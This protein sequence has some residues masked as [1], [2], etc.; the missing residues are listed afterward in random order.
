MNPND[1]D[2]HFRPRVRNRPIP[3]VH[4]LD[5]LRWAVFFIIVGAVLLYVIASN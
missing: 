5:V 3:V 1:W 4:G 2:H